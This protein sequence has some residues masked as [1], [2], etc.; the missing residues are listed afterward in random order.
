MRGFG[1]TLGILLA[2]GAVAAHADAAETALPSGTYRLELREVHAARFPLLGRTRTTWASVSLARLTRDS[3][4]LTQEHRLCDVRFESGLPLVEMVMPEPMRDSLARPPYTVVLKP[5]EEGGWRYR[6]DLGFEHVGYT[7]EEPG[8]PPPQQGDDPSIVDSDGDGK[9]G[10]TLHMVVPVLDPLELYVVQ[11]GHAV[12][13]G[14]VVEGGRVEG[15]LEAELEQVVIGSDP[16]F[17]KRNPEL[18]PEPAL[19]T[20]VL[21]PVPEDSTCESLLEA[22]EDRSDETDG[23]DAG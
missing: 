2:L 10:A 21:T 3:G 12:L 7:P 1:H 4:T 16:Y 17:L 15:A 14:R 19:S 6:A 23:P 11:R 20:F 13:D 18:E 22:S 5:D 8:A 9:P